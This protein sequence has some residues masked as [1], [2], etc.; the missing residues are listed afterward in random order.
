MPAE[1]QYADT[2]YCGGV[3]RHLRG[4]G[5]HGSDGNGRR[6]PGP[7]LQLEMERR[8]DAE[9]VARRIFRGEIL[10]CKGACLAKQLPL[11]VPSNLR[12]NRC[13]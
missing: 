9:E 13:P 12:R 4:D 10:S 7:S 1:V 5:R 8:S 11:P 2:C 6:A 3:L